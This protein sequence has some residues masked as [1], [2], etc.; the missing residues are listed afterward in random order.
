M[1]ASGSLASAER[2]DDR[3]L[4]SNRYD[5]YGSLCKASDDGQASLEWTAGIRG[6]A[7]T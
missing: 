7:P 1:L 4:C 2:R 6:E 5:L 3:R